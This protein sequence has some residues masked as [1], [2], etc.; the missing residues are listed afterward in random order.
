MLDTPV[1]FNFELTINSSKVT[2]T[3]VMEL[4]QGCPAVGNLTVEGVQVSEKFR[5]GG[6]AVGSEAYLYAPVFVEELWSAGFELAKINLN[7]LELE[8]IGEKKNLIFLDKIKNGHIYFYEDLEKTKR[9]RLR[10][11]ED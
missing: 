2:Y 3:N 6:P 11:H 10:I 1:N 7:S 9:N 4:C 8:L 5:F